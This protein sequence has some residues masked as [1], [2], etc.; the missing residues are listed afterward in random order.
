M[1]NSIKLGKLWCVPIIF[2]LYIRFIKGLFCWDLLYFSFFFFEERERDL[3]CVWSL[4]S[5]DN[6]CFPI[7]NPLIS[8]VFNLV[9]SLLFAFSVRFTQFLYLAF[10]LLEYFFI[11]FECDFSVFLSIRKKSKDAKKIQLYKKPRSWGIKIFVEGLY[12]FFSIWKC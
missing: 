3:Y 4:W 8:N 5:V 2:W 11:C 9:L 12:N 7:F 1:E 10:F 6:S